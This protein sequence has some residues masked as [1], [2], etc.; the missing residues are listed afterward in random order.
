[1]VYCSG[2]LRDLH[3]FP[4]RRSSDLTDVLI[5]ATGAHSPTISKELIYPKKPLLILDLSI[6]KNVSEDV[7]QME[8]VTVIH[9]DDLSQMTD[10]TLEKRKQYVPQAE[11]IIDEVRSEEHTSEL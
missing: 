4:T 8:N 3:S 1:S 10:D 6:P 5:V 9:L 11:A 2:A 7:S